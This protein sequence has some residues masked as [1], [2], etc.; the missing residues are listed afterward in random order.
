MC[1]I[2]FSPDISKSVIDSDDLHRAFQ[3]NKDGAGMAYIKNGN[4]ITDKAYFKYKH[5]KK[6]YDEVVASIKGPLIIHFRLS[7]SGHLNRENSHPFTV[8]RNKLVVA[9]N[10]IF[11]ELSYEDSKISDT[12][13]FV[14]MLKNLN[15]KFPYNGDQQKLLE[16]ACGGFNKLVFLD[17]NGKYIIINEDAGIWKDNAWYSNTHS[18]VVV[19]NERFRKGRNEEYDEVLAEEIARQF[20]DDER[21]Y[22][23]RDYAEDISDDR[24]KSVPWLH[25]RRQALREERKRLL[26]LTEVVRESKEGKSEMIGA[27]PPLDPNFNYNHGHSARFV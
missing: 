12:V 5:F 6:A 17:N 19:R 13:R 22:L 21:A 1:L 16:I 8:N 7:T 27:H 15:W 23:A 26:K 3:T 11:S 9:H 4:V 25:E 24:I 14:N 10:G 20:Q 2:I 18:F